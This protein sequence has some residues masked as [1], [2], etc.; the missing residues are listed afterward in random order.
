MGENRSGMTR[1]TRR[2]LLQRGGLSVATGMSVL[3]AGCL[4][5]LLPSG[6]ETSSSTPR[7]Q[8]TDSNTPLPP[9]TWEQETDWEYLTPTPQTQPTSETS[10]ST[11]RQTASETPS[12]TPQQTPSETPSPTPQSTA[13]ET[14][15]P[16]PQP[17][18]SK[19]P[20]PTPHQ[21]QNQLS[22]S[23]RPSYT[24]WLYSPYWNSRYPFN[25]VKPQSL[26]RH[27]SHLGYYLSDLLESIIDSGKDLNYSFE[28][29][30]TQIT[31]TG[32][33]S[34]V[35][36]GKF[37]PSRMTG[38]LRNAGFTKRGTYH[39]YR[40]FTRRSGSRPA[41]TVAVN[42]T[43][44]ISDYKHDSIAT[45]SVVKA[46]IDAKSGTRVRY[47]ERNNAFATLAG[48]LDSGDII[49]T[50]ISPAN[51]TTFS[52]LSAFRGIPLSIGGGSIKLGNTTSQ[53]TLV[54]VFGGKLRSSASTAVKKYIRTSYFGNVTGTVSFSQKGRVMV[55]KTDVPTARIREI[56]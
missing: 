54:H 15:S 34:Y 4:G 48:Y 50:G 24:T 25:V 20:S 30:G 41:G 9:M 11:P 16:T 37:N 38:G 27:R 33:N 2:Q 36:V 49:W 14:S 42:R 13:S 56:I 3:S 47:V 53:V 31:F 21:S 8:Q 35:T 6:G 29:I 17:T 1:S 10:L 19:T 18:A 28:S 12:S 46:I 40:L 32:G 39:G 45:K 51:R 22:G 44:L 26:Q 23:K 7:I 5:G 43:A 52:A 55:A